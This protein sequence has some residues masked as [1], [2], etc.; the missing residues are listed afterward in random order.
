[1]DAATKIKMDLIVQRFAELDAAAKDAAAALD[2]VKQIVLETMEQEQ[3]KT[4]EVT[5]GGKVYRATYVQATTHIIDE[6][7]LRE[8]L[9]DDLVDLYCKKVLDKPAL[10]AAM[11]SGEVSPYA[12]GLHVTERKNKPSVRFTARAAD[13]A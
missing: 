12:V 7:G 4:Y 6:E 9:G 13:D 11:E 5:D 2:A 3:I 1:M 10:E 8:E